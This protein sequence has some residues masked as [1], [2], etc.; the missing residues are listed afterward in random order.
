ME[1]AFHEGNTEGLTANQL[2][3]ANERFEQWLNFYTDEDPD[4]DMVKAVKERLLDR[5]A[6]QAP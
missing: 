4:P 6:E 3:W 2:A 5:A 1:S